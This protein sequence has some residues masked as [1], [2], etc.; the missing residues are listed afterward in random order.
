MILPALTEVPIRFNG[1]SMEIGTGRYH[2][3]AGGAKFR[4]PS[5]SSAL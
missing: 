1:F 5:C 4:N 3:S 2:E